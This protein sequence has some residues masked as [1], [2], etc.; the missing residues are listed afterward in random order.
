MAAA[1]VGVAV[2]LLAP[3]AHADEPD[4]RGPSDR[5][6]PLIGGRK[7]HE[8]PQNFAAELRFGLFNPDIDSDPAL[9]SSSSPGA[10]YR[11]VFGTAPRLLISAEL[12][13][14]AYR[15][16][17]IGTIGPGASIGYSSMSDPAHF[18][19]PQNGVTI[20]GE[21]TTLEIVPVYAAIVLRADGLWR[22]ARIPVVPYAK[23]GLGLSFWRASN[24][25]GTSTYKGVSG[26][27]S[28]LGSHYALGVAIN[29]N[30][31]DEYAA[32]GF[33]D[34]MGVN[35]TYI[36]GEWTRA[37]LTGL[38]LQSDPLRVG[39]TSWTFGLAWEF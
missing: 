13:W 10:P 20:S 24:T 15:I 22:Q 39:G 38:G 17:Y 35:G 1:S 16:P 5:A 14:Q 11:T 29:L 21:T 23:L 27:G 7:A 37:D 34:A 19:T 32:R 12:D 18:V 8:S 25:L 9:H 30:P 28:S 31:F 26:T 33:D 6:D 4:L 36:F 2:A 3:L